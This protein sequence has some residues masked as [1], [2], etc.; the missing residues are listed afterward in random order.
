MKLLWQYLE[1]IKSFPLKGPCERH[2]LCRMR[3]Q[4]LHVYVAGDPDQKFVRF[5]KG[6]EKS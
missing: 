5:K 1:D 4:P 3:W 2:E 6:K